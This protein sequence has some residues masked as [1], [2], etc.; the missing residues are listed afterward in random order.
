MHKKIFIDCGT[1]MFQGFE[2]F[3]NKFNIDSTWECYSFEANPITY[4]IS[5]PKYD[6]LINSGYSIK[7]YNYAISDHDGEINVHCDIAENGTGQASNTLENRPTEDKLWGFNLGYLDNQIKVVS[8]D[9]VKF[10]EGI[11]NPGDYLLIKMDIEGSEFKVLDS[12]MSKLDT[13]IIG[14]MYVE[15]HERFFDDEDLY[16]RKKD[17]YFAHFNKNGTVLSDWK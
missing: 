17:L 12:I 3:A 7:H 11:Y 2:E 1:H 16:R 10:I 9:L 4:N 14:D 8:I 6:E 13:S 5:K 15:F